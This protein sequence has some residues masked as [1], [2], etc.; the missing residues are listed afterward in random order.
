MWDFFIK[1]ALSE[2]RRFI[3]LFYMLWVV[4]LFLLY[5]RKFENL[6][7]FLAQN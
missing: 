2:Y 1:G 3:Y 5:A 4:F 6:L 7:F